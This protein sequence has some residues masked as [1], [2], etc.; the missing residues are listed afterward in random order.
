[1]VRRSAAAFLT[2]GY[3]GTSIE[4]LVSA[5]GLHRGSLYKAFGSKRGLFVTCLEAV[6]KSSPG[7]DATDLTLVALLELAPRDREV[8][9]ILAAHVGPESAHALGARLLE[10]AHI[11]ATQGESR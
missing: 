5:T 4:E 8:R 7:N 11:P 10:R 1:M 9:T 6:L 3:E 2:S